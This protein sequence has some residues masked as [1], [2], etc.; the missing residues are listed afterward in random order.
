MNTQAFLSAVLPS[1]G[2]YCVVGLKENT[3]PKQK[4]VDS[5][6][7]VI[8]LSDQLVHAGFNSY[9]ALSTFTNPK[10]GRKTDNSSHLKSFFIDLDCGIG[11]AYADKADGLTALKKFIKDTGMPKPIVVNSGNGIHAYWALSEPLP[12]FIWK[13]L[14]EKLKAL[15]AQEKLHAD[16]SVTADT[17][18]VLR[19]PETLNYKDINN[20]LPVTVIRNN[21]GPIDISVIQDVLNKLDGG[22]VFEQM[23]GKPFVPKEMDAMTL[24]LMGNSQSRFKTIL[25]KSLNGE[26]CAQLLR[27]YQNQD[28]IDEPLWRGGLSIANNCVDRDKAIHKISDQ[29]PQYNAQDTEKKANQTKGPYTCAT[30]RKLFAEGCQGCK[31]NI[32]SPIQLGK[33]IV[34]ATEEDNIVQEVSTSSKEK[35]QF[36]IP[37]YPF[38]YFRGKVGGIYVRSKNPETDEEE[39]ILI[40]PY[41]FYV[42]KRMIDPDLGEVILL[43]LH[44]PKDG[45]REFIVPLTSVASK[46]KFISAVSSYGV[47]VLGKKQEVLMNYI[48]KW[49]EE[50][51]AL[52]EAEKARKQFGWTDD[53][54]SFILGDKEIRATEV[55]YS[56]PTS[57]TLPLV[58]VFREKG[59]FHIWKDVVNIYSQPAMEAK[60]FAFF[61][62]FGNVLL[63]YIKPELYGYILSL[64]SQG[65]GTG[66]STILHIIASIYGA[67]KQQM[68][69]TKDTYNQKLNRIGAMQ[70]LPILFDEMTNLP[71]EHKSSLVY[72]ITEGRAKNRMTSQANTERVNSTSWCT[73]IIT[74]TNRS[75][76][77]DLLSIKS[78]PDGEL[79]RIVALPFYQDSNDDP[80]KARAHFGRLY[81]NYGHAALPFLQYVLANLP[82][83]VKFVN[84]LQAKLDRITGLSSSERYWSAIPAL[85]LAGGIISRNL[86]LHDIDHKPVMQYITKHI[87]ASKTENK[88]LML[89]SSDFLGGFIN[90]KFHEMLIINGGKDNRTGLEYGPIREP[91]GALT[92]RYEPDTKLLFVVAKEYRIECNK[93][94]L[95]FDE[96]LAM[97]IKSGAYVGTKRK[98]MTAGTVMGAEINVPALVFDSTKLD[99]FREDKFLNAPNT[100]PNLSDSV[101]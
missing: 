42:V 101:G 62:G 28:I 52:G 16:T 47:L 41:D 9:F 5:I 26:G 25:I 84:D 48:G 64:E 36:K 49:V 2:N 12:S 70:H 98:R 85:A 14:A 61:M 19:I 57:A 71:A 54:S 1:E 53:D 43:R 10:G 63:K 4:F 67:P 83:V 23:S 73:G 66:K 86:G 55:L 65:S 39:E 11:K 82:Q 78:M 35:T 40:Y 89:E 34:E 69:L 90:R 100:E 22:D 32:S 3:T 75:L 51:Q 38:P 96:S 7:K 50:L 88:I 94:K 17:A 24:A 92:I 81:D 60:A 74:T 91:R 44:L 31:Q 87:M 20:P 76:R 13:P 30:F 27:I 8:E 79:N 15:C 72:D 33:E 58:P 59:D 93:G 80:I 21:E 95:N 77:D 46:E 45:V 97:H 6:D 56:P 29:H 18:R 37:K 99:F 68:M